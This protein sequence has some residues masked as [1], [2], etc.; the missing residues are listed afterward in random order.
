[1]TLS[2]STFRPADDACLLFLVRHG[3]TANNLERPP[4][5]QGRRSDLPLSEE[6]RRQAAAAA[7]FLA[8]FPIDA[9]FSSPLKRA[10]QTAEIIAA[11]HGGQPAGSV[12]ARAIAVTPAATA[13]AATAG[14]AEVGIVE[15]LAECDVGDWEGRTWA[16]IERDDP[17]GYRRFMTAPEKYGYAGGENL[18]QLLERVVP[19]LEDLLR[20]H[21][22]QTICVVAH[23]VVNRALMGHLM[24]LPLV[25]ARSI[26]QDNCGINLLRWRD[27]RLK[28]QTINA[29]FHLEP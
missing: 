14:T 27:R 22:G 12:A 5:I 4:R 13:V 10:R 28:V 6:G 21:L 24:G 1:M 15:P 3:A 23:N 19:A 11:R 17:E 2:F 8:P 20:R 9:F 16:D 18:T 29:R 25:K 26:P 7:E